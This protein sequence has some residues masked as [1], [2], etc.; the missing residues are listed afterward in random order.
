MHLQ[1]PL[2]TRPYIRR[3]TC[4]WHTSK[5][6]PV[7]Q[8]LPFPSHVDVSMFDM[9][10]I[11]ESVRLA[12]NG[13]PMELLFLAARTPREPACVVIAK[14]PW[15]RRSAI[16]LRLSQ[17]SSLRKYGS[18]STKL[19]RDSVRCF[20]PGQFEVLEV[21]LADLIKAPKKQRARHV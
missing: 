19:H 16:Q 2:H 1:A 20:L 18:T 5:N 14:D 4:P 17:L 9:P 21:C 13:L 3:E 6:M 15:C 12:C 10:G 11:T 8:V 7:H